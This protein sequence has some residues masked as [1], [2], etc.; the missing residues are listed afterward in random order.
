VNTRTNPPS[1]MVWGG[2]R[3][4]KGRETHNILGDWTNTTTRIYDSKWEIYNTLH[5]YRRSE[6]RV[7]FPQLVP[8]LQDPSFPCK[9]LFSFAYKKSKILS[10]LTN[11]NDGNVEAQ[12]I[13]QYYVV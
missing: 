5:K 6:P 3:P 2:Y 11:T 9:H 12:F 1:Q 4:D 7:Y 13:I 10:Y 8:R